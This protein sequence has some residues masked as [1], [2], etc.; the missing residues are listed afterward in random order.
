MRYY[1]FAFLSATPSI[2][3]FLFY[4]MHC[5]YISYEDQRMNLHLHRQIWDFCCIR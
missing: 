2:S 4:Y 1:T 3:I 5:F